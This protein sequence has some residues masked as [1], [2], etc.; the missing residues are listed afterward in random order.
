MLKLNFAHIREAIA[1][2]TCYKSIVG[3]PEIVLTVFTHCKV[4]TN[5]RLFV[6]VSANSLAGGTNNVFP[7]R[8]NL[9]FDNKYLTKHAI[10]QN[11][12]NFISLDFYFTLMHFFFADHMLWPSACW[13]H[14][15]CYEGQ[16]RNYPKLDTRISFF[17][18]PPSRSYYPTWNLKLAGLESSGRI[19]S[20]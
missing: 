19:V 4:G 11:P 1:V 16:N 2:Y 18:R 3:A 9:S 7:Q 15:T 8:F 12:L 17:V 10:K 20:S 5:W 13:T 6:S 14:L